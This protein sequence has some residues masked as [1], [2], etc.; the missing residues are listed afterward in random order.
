MD[1]YTQ[2]PNWM[3]ARLYRADGLTLRE[4]RVLIFIIRKLYGF[5]KSSDKISYGQISE[6][7]GIDKS[8]VI[9]TVSSLEKKNVISVKR[10]GNRTNIIRIKGSGQTD[11]TSGV[12]KSR[13]VVA[14]STPTKENQKSVTS[15]SHSLGECDT[16]EKEISIAELNKMLGDDYE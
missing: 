14:K 16:R 1:N 13:R 8:N 7:T 9:K 12:K 10:K 6:G 11:T 3:M 5:H 4:L 15:C 2:I